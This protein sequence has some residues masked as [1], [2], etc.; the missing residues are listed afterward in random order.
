[1]SAIA[2][3]RL[4][5]EPPALETGS[6]DPTL[7]SSG[8]DLFL[9]YKTHN[10]D[11]PGWSSGASPDHPGF[12][13]KVAVVRFELARAHKF[14]YQNSEALAGHPLYKFGLQFYAFQI[15]EHSP[16]IAELCR[17]N[18]VHPRNSAA[19]WDG[20]T[21]WIV[22]FEDDTL[23]VIGRSATVAGVFDSISPTEALQR[24]TQTKTTA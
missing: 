3:V 4:W 1:M 15:V 24:V 13:E 19:L 2:T 11:F 17:Q 12:I 10:P 9:A 21:H 7:L 23:E 8:S 14:G 16:W 22:T 5:S 6:A 20:L 18:S